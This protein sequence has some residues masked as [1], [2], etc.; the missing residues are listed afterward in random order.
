MGTAGIELKATLKTPKLL[1]L[2]NGKNDKNTE[3][4]QLMYTPGTR[5]LRSLAGAAHSFSFQ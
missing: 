3:F 4:T 2:L 5:R 1:I